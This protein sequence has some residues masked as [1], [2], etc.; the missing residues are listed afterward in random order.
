MNGM[1]LASMVVLSLLVVI[2]QSMPNL[3]QASQACSVEAHLQMPCICCKKDCWYSVAAAATHEL[4]HMPGE[5][6]E[7]EAMAT[8]KLIRACMIADCAPICSQ[9]P[10]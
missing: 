3:P 8:L 10:L 1:M 4:G 5:A 9:S 2:A 7:R 6:G